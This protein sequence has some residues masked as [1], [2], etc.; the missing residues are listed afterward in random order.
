MPFSNSEM[1]ERMKKMQEESQWLY[2]NIARMEIEKFSV[3]EILYQIK[4]DLEKSDS[5]SNNYICKRNYKLLDNIEKSNH[6]QVMEEII[7]NYGKDDYVLILH[8]LMP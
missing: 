1:N 7:Q 6:N 8:F 4:N 5:L 2:Q 3:K